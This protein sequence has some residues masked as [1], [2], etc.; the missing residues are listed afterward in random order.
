LGVFPPGPF[1]LTL[2][3]TCTPGA[4]GGATQDHF[5]DTTRAFLARRLDQL[6]TEAPDRNRLVRRLTGAASGGAGTA[7]V[8]EGNGATAL[9]F[10]GSL[11]QIASAA[12]EKRAAQNGA[13]PQA[14]GLG[15]AGPPR[16]ASS[17]RNAFDVWAEGHVT[18]FEDDVSGAGRD[19]DVGLV[20][21]G[22]DYL[23]SPNLLLGLIVQFDWTKDDVPG[24]DSHFDGDG[25]MAGPYLSARLTDNLFLDVRAAWGQSDNGLAIGGA[26]ASFDADRWLVSA[27]LAGNWT[28][29]AWRLSPAIGLTY[30]EEEHDSYSTSTGIDVRS[31]TVAL[32]RLTFGPEIGYR[33]DAGGGLSIEPHVAIKGLWD[34]DHEDNLAINGVAVASDDFRARLEGGVLATL[35]GG[36]GLR[37]TGSYDGLGAADYEAWGGQ[38]W[39]NVPLN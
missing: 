1:N 25:W 36:L 18:R 11:N 32:G 17:S 12:R 26:T 14:S 20:Y 21:A 23:F 19:G 30:A 2:T 27:N 22:A 24:L 39:V 37:A 10:S 29:G 34:F 6:V 15:L 13:W 4:A 31:Q 3:A 35:P 38:L 16:T 28:R 8:T 7:S 33:F 5:E 9:N